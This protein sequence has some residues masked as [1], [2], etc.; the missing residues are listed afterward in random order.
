LIFV[1][2]GTQKFQM[3]RLLIKIDEMIKSGTLKEEVVAQTGYST[4]TPS[5]FESHKMLPS[6]KI[7]ELISKS[8]LCIC[9][10]G[11]SSIIQALKLGKKV[12][13]VPRKQEFNEHVDDHQVEIAQLF[14]G[15]GYIEMT[16]QVDD[17]PSVLQF[18]E[19]KSY[20]RYN[21]D[22]KK[23]ISSI[24]EDVKNYL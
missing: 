20:K 3:D 11:T 18:L 16:E 19:T 6:D 5:F 4:Y 14:Y 22:N 13:V 7:H 17:L 15:M 2:L 10:A 23:L 24:N 8:S 12:I 21:F 1:T 9:H